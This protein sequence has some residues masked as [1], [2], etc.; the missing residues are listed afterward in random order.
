MRGQL[1][2]DFGRHHL[3]HHLQ[4]TGCIGILTHVLD[5]GRSWGALDKRLVW[6]EIRV[7]GIVLHDIAGTVVHL[8]GVGLLLHPGT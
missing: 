4:H 3:A 1:A 6:R 8:L 7:V 5:W 2:V